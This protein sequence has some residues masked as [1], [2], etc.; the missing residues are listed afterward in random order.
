MFFSA[1][2]VAFASSLIGPLSGGFEQFR[3]V[4]PPALAAPQPRRMAATWGKRCWVDACIHGEVW[5][6]EAAIKGGAELGLLGHGS[7]YT[8]LCPRRWGSQ[9]PGCIPPWHC[10][11]GAFSVRLESLLGEAP[12][13]VQ[14]Y[15][16]TMMSSRNAETFVS[17]CIGMLYCCLF[18]AGCLCCSQSS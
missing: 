11:P 6:P 14:E 18:K 5:W 9:A 17:H 4:M 12:F 10:W 3:C 16:V 1:G 13:G 2:V 15:L 7:T 8:L